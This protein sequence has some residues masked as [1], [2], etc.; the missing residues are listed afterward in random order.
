MFNKLLQD[1]ALGEG[2]VPRSSSKRPLPKSPSLTTGS[3]A[4]IG[5]P[6]GKR[7]AEPMLSPANEAKASSGSFVQHAPKPVTRASTPRPSPM[8]VK[9]ERLSANER[10]SLLKEEDDNIRQLTS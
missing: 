10:P 7:H 3:S 9:K 1:N 8:Q 6:K 4:S 5:D 2:N